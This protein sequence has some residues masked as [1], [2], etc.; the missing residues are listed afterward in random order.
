MTWCVPVETCGIY[1][2]ANTLPL[3]HV[4]GWKRIQND[5]I[6]LFIMDYDSLVLE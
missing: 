3:V 4:Y 2:D 5:D 1:A 6:A